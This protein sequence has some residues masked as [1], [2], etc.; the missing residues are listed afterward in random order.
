LFSSK[1][2]INNLRIF[3]K[4]LRVTHATI[5]VAAA[6]TTTTT[7]TTTLKHL[8]NPNPKDFSC[9]WLMTASHKMISQKFVEIALNT[10]K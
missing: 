4:F 10:T 2:K 8:K 6:A 1:S 3:Q 5:Y 9:V 7:S